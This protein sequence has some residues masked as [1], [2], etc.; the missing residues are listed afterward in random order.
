M[1]MKYALLI[2]MSEY[3]DAE[4]PRLTAPLADVRE[5]ADILRNNDV[6]A[7]D[8]VDVIRNASL[9]IAQR[10]IAQLCHE[11][12]KDDLILLYF[13]GHGIL[14]F[15][16]DLFFAVSDTT[17]SE[18]YATALNAQ[19]IRDVLNKSRS[20]RQILILDCCHS[21]AFAAGTKGV[22]VGAPAMTRNTFEV[23]GYGR[24]VL[25]SNA[26]TQFAWEGNTV[27]GNTDRS[28]FTH[29]LVEGLESGQAG[30]QES[31]FITVEG[32]S[33]CS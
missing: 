1:L 27:L 32:L 23:D 15:S 4:L 25:T 6:G 21:G 2:G 24:E 19:F 13:S 30:S 17:R 33:V 3:E 12:N 10:R 20:R 8:R 18:L 7:F 29:F 14:D 16:G 22:A 9:T 11:K 28:L 26:A 5:F 31:S